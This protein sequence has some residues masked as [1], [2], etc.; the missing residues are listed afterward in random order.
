MWV[1]LQLYVS[2]HPD[3]I[4]LS[5]HILTA[6]TLYCFNF[7][8]LRKLWIKPWNSYNASKEDRKVA[9]SSQFNWKKK[10]NSISNLTT[11][12]LSTR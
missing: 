10:S 4:Y 3:Q 6:K 9:V 1:S 11:I 2:S 12:L 7:S 8:L 5:C